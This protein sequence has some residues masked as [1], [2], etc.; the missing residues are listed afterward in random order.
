MEG[1]KM[2]RHLY[3]FVAIQT[4]FLGRFN[5]YLTEKD[6]VKTLRRLEFKPYNHLRIRN[7]GIETYN[8]SEKLNNYN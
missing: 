5:T 8:D 6:K 3:L 1:L 7:K 4:V 2:C